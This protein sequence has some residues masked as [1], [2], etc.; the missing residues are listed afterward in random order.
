MLLLLLKTIAY[1]SNNHKLYKEYKENAIII[2]MSEMT[3]LN[4]VELIEKTPIA[5]LSNN[6]QNK[7]A[8]KIKN[9]FL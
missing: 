9:K 8:I 4:I 5:S 1:A 2:F 7:L 6:Y 3:S